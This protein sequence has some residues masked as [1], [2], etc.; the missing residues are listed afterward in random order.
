MTSLAKRSLTKESVRQSL[1]DSLCESEFV[2]F[3][4]WF[5]LGA[6]PGNAEATPVS[7][8]REERE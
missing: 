8:Q 7:V 4:A 1:V 2:A 6:R 3:V 5:I